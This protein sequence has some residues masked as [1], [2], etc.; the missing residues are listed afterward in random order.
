MTLPKRLWSVAINSR[1]RSAVDEVEIVAQRRQRFCTSGS[2]AISPISLAEALD[3]LA[4]RLGRRGDAEPD[5]D[6]EAR[7]ALSAIVGTCG[8]D[9]DAL[10]RRD[11]QRLHLAGLDVRHHRVRRRPDHRDLS[12]QQ[13]VERRRRAAIGHV[14]DVD[15]GGAL[16][17]SSREM[18]RRA[19]ARRADRQLAGIGLGDARSAP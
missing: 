5:A 19:D 7:H 9:R 8:S 2:L 15:L 11:A 6:I 12:A 1:K 18:M 17:I 13:I 14:D 3:E 16:S 10:R 4:R